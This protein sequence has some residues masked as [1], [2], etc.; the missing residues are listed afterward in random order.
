MSPRTPHPEPSRR[1]ATAL[2][3]LALLAIAAPA[4]ADDDDPDPDNAIPSTVRI[5]NSRQAA[6][7]EGEVT[8]AVA[9]SVVYA[10]LTDPTRWPAIFPRVRAVTIKPGSRGT[11]VEIISRKGKRRNLRF[12]NEARTLTVRFTE[13]GGAADVNAEIVL[14]A[15]AQGTTRA[16]ARLHADVTGFRS[17]F[18]SDSTIRAK[19]ERKLAKYLAD[20]DRYFTGRASLTAA[21]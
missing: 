7:S 11:E 12:A 18:V 10:A 8:L 19:R 17:L 16:R 13:S 9:P 15:T 4:W 3:A 21:P 6:T 2:L 14:I 20:L 5:W 1:W